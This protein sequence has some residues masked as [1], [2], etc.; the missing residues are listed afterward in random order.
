MH[1]IDELI[2]EH[3]CTHDLNDSDFD[4]DT[5]GG[6]D[7]EEDVDVASS[8]TTKLPSATCN[9]GNKTSSNPRPLKVQATIQHPDPLQP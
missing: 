5:S 6:S 1:E 7:N 9:Q 8:H 4:G 3:A 2:N